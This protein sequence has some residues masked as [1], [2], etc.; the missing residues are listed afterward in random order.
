MGFGNV[1]LGRPS[2]GQVSSADKKAGAVIQHNLVDLPLCAD[3]ARRARLEKVPA[4]WLKYYLANTFYG[5]FE[6][7]HLQI[8]DG[9][10]EAHRTGGRFLVAAERGIGKSV[11]L[12]GMVLYLALTGQQRYPIC[13]PWADKALKRAFRFWKMA[14]CF[15]DRLGEDYPEYCAPFRHARG[16]PQRVAT[17]RWRDDAPGGRHKAEDMTGAQLTVGEGI[18]VLPDQRGCIGGSTINGNVRGLNHPQEDGAVLRPT[19]VLLDDVQDRKTAKSPI[20]VQDTVDIIDGDVAGVGEAGSQVPML[21]SGNCIVPDDVMAHYLNS[22]EWKGLRVPCVLEWPAGWDDEKSECRKL[23]AEWYDRFTGND[24][25][26]AFYRAHKAAMTR[27]MRLSA[28]AA[29]RRAEKAADPL[30]GAMRAYHK[31]GRDAF[32]AEKQQDPQ[33]QSSS[34]YRLD[35]ATILSRVSG[36]PRLEAPSGAVLCVGIDVN[37]VGLNWSAVAAD[38]LT[39]TRKVVAHGIWPERGGLIPKGA[40][41]DQACGIIR[42]AIGQF[43]NDV[44]ARLRV[45]CGDKQKMIEAA[46]YDCSMGAWQDAMVAAIRECRC[47]VTLWPIKAFGSRN[48]RGGKADLR[49]GKGWRITEW[50]QLGRV[51]VINADYWRETM[52]RGF[53]VEPTEAGAISL[54]SPDPDHANRT[55]A[56]EV[57]GERLDEHVTTE[58]NEF[59]K[60]VRTP[61]VP[62]DRA[63]S[64]VY[65]CALT[66]VQGIGED[67]P[68]IVKR[69]HGP[70]MTRVRHIEI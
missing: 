42:R 35:E 70:A 34:L 45:R 55:L 26:T 14:L 15:N 63:D 38:V 27:G 3:P 50:P 28:P 16:V 49:V 12:W 24:G 47:G 23:W 62:N 68:R 31:M 9:T 18:I 30:L 66:G 59:Y 37:Y 57:A 67:R 52:Q 11:V 2:T 54:Y 10:M 25:A 20:Q 58:K 44:L 39:R 13:V 17:T 1:K 61:G 64:L 65:A 7:P 19:L 8:I 69:A 6:T 41:V 21:M 56:R 5:P 33:R 53:L 40:T 43:S 48:Y 22:R 60:W 46:G 4:K 36:F 29:F 32:L 51:L